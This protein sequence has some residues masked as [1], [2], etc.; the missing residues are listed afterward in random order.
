MAVTKP[1]WALGAS[2][3]ATAGRCSLA[4]GSGLLEGTGGWLPALLSGMEAWASGET[5]GMPEP[6]TCAQLPSGRVQNQGA[7]GP[8]C[9][10]RGRVPSL[11]LQWPPACHLQGWGAQ[12]PMIWSASSPQCP[13]SSLL[14]P[15]A[16]SLLRCIHHATPDLAP[17]RLSLRASQ[18]PPIVQHPSFW[19]GL[20]PCVP[21]GCPGFLH[22]CEPSSSVH[23]L[24]LPSR[25]SCLCRSG[26]RPRPQLARDMVCSRGSVPGRWEGGSGLSARKSVPVVGGSGTAA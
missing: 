1:P 3:M 5:S 16:A 9:T 7:L 24:P 25:S 13:R 21:R 17:T 26:E 19:V 10:G 14:C 4:P 6:P 23:S 20:H 8:L 15:R 22:C 18:G 11:Q 12:H 2:R